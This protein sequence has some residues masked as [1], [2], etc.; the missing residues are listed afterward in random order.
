M[1]V[2]VTECE[3]GFRVALLTADGEQDAKVVPT[4]AEAFAIQAAGE[5]PVEPKP[6]PE[7][8]KKGKKK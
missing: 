7:V 2:R 4:L 1:I 5:F 3:G 6:E 8:A